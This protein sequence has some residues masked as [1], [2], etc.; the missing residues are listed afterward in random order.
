MELMTGGELFD[1]LLEKEQF[2]EKEARDVI[3]PIIDAIGYCHSLGIVHRDIKPENLLFSSVDSETSIIKVSDFGLARFIDDEALATTTCGT[4]GY[5][6]PEILSQKPYGQECDYWSIGVV[7]FILL[8]GMPPFYDEDNFV[9]FEKIKKGEFDFSAPSWDSISDGPKDIISKLLI[10]DP[11][12]RIK[13]SD[14]LKH[15][16]IKGEIAGQDIGVL[17][18]MREWNSKRK[19]A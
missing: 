12:Q 8:S 10:V 13:P 9:L 1:V 11:S 18:K 17:G 3:R 7:L 16:W 4:P 2:S 5:V 19:L 14:L 6:A 15:P